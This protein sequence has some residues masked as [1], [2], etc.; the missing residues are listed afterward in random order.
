MNSQRNL[1]LMARIAIAAIITY[2]VL[3]I[4]LIFLR[5][6]LDPTWHSISEWA[7]GKYGWLMTAGFLISGISYACLFAAIRKEVRGGV[8]KTGVALLLIC[9]IGTFG[10]CI[11]TT[12]PIQMLGNPTTRGM[13]HIIFGTTALI[14]FPFAALIIAFNIAKRNATWAGAKRTL[15]LTALIPLLGFLGFVI[16]TAIYVVPKGPNAYGPGVNIGLPPRFAF[17]TYM[18]WIIII[19]SKFISVKS[20]AVNY[21]KE[22]AKNTVSVP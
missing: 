8:G 20:A 22:V 3:L 5:P 17:L 2:Q 4:V 12:D 7:I 21:T 10:V 13:F 14:L 16:Y 6:D 1:L 9:V 19:S 15:Q 18:V 11:F